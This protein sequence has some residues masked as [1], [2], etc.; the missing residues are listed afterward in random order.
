MERM[1]EYMEQNLIPPNFEGRIDSWKNIAAFLGRDERTVQRWEKERGIPV[2]RVPGKRGAVFAYPAELLA[3]LHRSGSDLDGTGVL[4]APA[5]QQSAETPVDAAVPHREASR[6]WGYAMAGIVGTLLIIA[7][8]AFGWHRAHRPTALSL[9]QTSV[10]PAPYHP[11]QRARE[12]YLDGSFYWNRRDRAS[13]DKALVSF[14][15]AAQ[16]DPDYGDAYVG[17]AETYELM[18]EFGNTRTKV[19]YPLAL[20][21]AQRAVELA[22]NSADAHRV[23]AF[24]QFYWAW[25]A[26][27]AFAEFR[28]SIELDPLN[29]ETHHWYANALFTLRQIGPAEAEIRQARDLDPKSRS[30]LADSLLIGCNDPARHS[31]SL[32]RLVEFEAA[33]PDFVSGPRYLADAYIRDHDYSGYLR[34]TA[35]IAAITHSPDDIAVAKVVAKGWRTGGERGMWAA[36]RNLEQFDFQEGRTSGFALGITCARLGDTA[37]GAKFL[38]MAY[39]SRDFLLLTLLNDF[40]DPI[41]DILQREPAYRDMRDKMQRQLSAQA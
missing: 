5:S 6:S 18:P 8:G 30:I 36:L 40:N 9:A 1:R 31:I 12:L 33:E 10:A 27:L 28:R 7:L 4:L 29:P 41:V 17:I 34:E 3:W 21:A 19:A 15:Q 11:S 35:R 14:Q 39:D 16:L 13:L 25:H 20:S 26:D 22:P 38:K 23:L 24:V 2:H 32:S 37:N